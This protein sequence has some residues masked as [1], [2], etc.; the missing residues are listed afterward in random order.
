MRILLDPKVANTVI[1]VHMQM[2]MEWLIAKNVLS[3]SIVPGLAPVMHVIAQIAHLQ[4]LQMFQGLQHAQVVRSVLLVILGMAAVA[5]L[6][7]LVN[8][9]QSENILQ[10]IDANCVQLAH[11]K[12]VLERLS[13][14]IAGSE[15]MELLLGQCHPR[16]V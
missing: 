13:A 6:M 8:L 5:H 16:V 7:V 1:R 2:Q 3:E 9:V 4:H 14:K 15:N 10:I 12:I 11:I